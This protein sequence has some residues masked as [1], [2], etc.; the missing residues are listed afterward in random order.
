M[1]NLIKTDRKIL[2]FFILI[3]LIIILIGCGKETVKK[4]PKKSMA[5]IEKEKVRAGIKGFIE[6]KKNN[7]NVYWGEGVAN[8]GNDLGEAKIQANN[9][10]LEDLT[11]T[12]EVNVQSDITRTLSGISMQTGKIYSE[13]IEDQI[14]QKTKIYTD[15]II[16]DVKEKSYLD[17]P[18]DGFVTNFVYI[19]KSKYKERVKK[20]LETKRTMIRTAIIGG[21]E[22]FENRNYMTALNN[23]LNAYQYIENFFGELPLLVDLNNDSI[24]VEVHSYIDGKINKFFGSIQ[25][26]RL[27]SK[28]L[29]EGNKKVFYNMQGKVNRQPSFYVQYE[30][31]NGEKFPISQFP[32]S[33]KIVEGEG[34]ITNNITTGN[35]GQAELRINYIEPKNKFS[36]IKV[37]IDIDEIN[38]LNKFSLPLLSSLTINLEK[39]KSMAL[40]VKFYNYDQTEK[41][42]NLESKL[43]TLLMDNGYSVANI[44]IKGFNV[45][46]KDIENAKKTNA[47][48]F[49]AINLSSGNTS[50]VG[51]YD[52]MYT[53]NCSGIISLYNLETGQ[54]VATENIPVKSGFGVSAQGAGWDAFGKR[55]NLTVDKTRNVIGK[56]K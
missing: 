3:L 10:A 47:D 36:T 30:N 23:W 37:K 54:I 16:K 17:Y 1:S 31:S 33:A 5:E 2:K 34:K 21:N 53:A 15:Q 24:M 6:S 7:P 56:I 26:S 32:L 45:N 49:L 38:G 20:D 52:N 35:Y 8:I 9:R 18:K 19:S 39:E 44:L 41:S 51:G 11:K 29:N 40:S 48:Y 27:T 22:E 14:T 42:P 28:Q 50:K 12:I 25:L 55:I 4:E 13:H 46:D 43:K